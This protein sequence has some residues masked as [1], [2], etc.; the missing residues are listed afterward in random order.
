MTLVLD[1]DNPLA[2]KVQT[3]DGRKARLIAVDR[4]SEFSI[5]ALFENGECEGFGV[6]LSNGRAFKNVE[7][8]ID[9]INVPVTHKRWINIY[10]YLSAAFKSRKEADEAAINLD[11]IACIFVEFKEGEG[12]D[13]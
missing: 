4:K 9:L 3:R 2:T 8:R 12:L 10:P 5:I 7:S 1:K 13:K 6:F 11:R